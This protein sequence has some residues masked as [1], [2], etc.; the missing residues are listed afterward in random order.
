MPIPALINGLLPPGVHDA[1][2]DEVEAIF[3]SSNATRVDL[4][5]KLKG[6]IATLKSFGLFNAL[7]V[8]GSFTTD[9]V[10]PHDIDVVVDMSVGNLAM[11]LVKPNRNAVLDGSTLK[12]KYGIHQFFAPSSPGMINFFQHL[13]PDEAIMRKVPITTE[14]GILRVVL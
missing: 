11:L 12:T 9:K 4:C 14:R 10:D 7:Y 2:L 13:R 6:Y 8:D 3:G 5:Q 1:T